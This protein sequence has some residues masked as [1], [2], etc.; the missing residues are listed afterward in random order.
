MTICHVFQGQS[1]FACCHA[2]IIN[3]ASLYFQ[4]CPVRKNYRIGGL[5]SSCLDEGN[6][7][8]ES[9]PNKINGLY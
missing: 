8:E 6:K 9:N 4:K 3:S 5:N 2:V 7:T 1:S